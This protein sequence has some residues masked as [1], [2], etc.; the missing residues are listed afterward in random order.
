LPSSYTRNERKDENPHQSGEE[1][2]R[3]WG[4]AVA[5]KPVSEELKTLIGQDLKK[6]W[7]VQRD[8]NLR[9][10]MKTL[11][12]REDCTGMTWKD[13]IGSLGSYT[14]KKMR[15]KST[16]FFWLKSGQF[17][18]AAGEDLT[19]TIVFAAF[20]NQWIRSHV[21]IPPNIDLRQ[22]LCRPREGSFNGSFHGTWDHSNASLSVK[23]SI[24]PYT[25]GEMAGRITAIF[26]T[27]SASRYYCNSR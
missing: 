8:R 7:F 2:D 15:N 20:Y 4:A 27:C 23:T 21:S 14:L 16:K 9:M 1:V 6:D 5:E 12:T 24:R 19:P 25:P 11:W 22:F 10:N 26:D 17:I 3:Y 13:T 18:N